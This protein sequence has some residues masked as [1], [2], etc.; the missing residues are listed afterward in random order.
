[1]IALPACAIL[2]TAS[3]PQCPPCFARCARTNR[4]TAGG[5]KDRVPLI[6]NLQMAVGFT[7]DPP[8]RTRLSPVATIAR[9][10]IVRPTGLPRTCLLLAPQP[11][12]ASACR[13]K[14]LLTGKPRIDQDQAGDFVSVYLRKTNR[15]DATI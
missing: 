12:V 11:L 9:Y 13:Q 2:P 1:M 8:K 14:A 7:F 6:A 15:V 4:D 10:L 5:V 3:L